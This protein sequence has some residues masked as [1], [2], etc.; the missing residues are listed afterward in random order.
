MHNIIYEQDNGRFI[1][2]LNTVSSDLQKI[3]SRV[4]DG[5]GTIGRLLV[6]PTVYEDLMLILSEVKRNKLLKTLIRFG[7]SLNETPNE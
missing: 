7:I 6:D 2:N 4:K 3:V 5:E 1:E